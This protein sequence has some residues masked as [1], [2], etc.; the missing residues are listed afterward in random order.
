MLELPDSKAIS[1]WKHFNTLHLPNGDTLRSLRLVVIQE[2]VRSTRRF[3]ACSDGITFFGEA[4]SYLTIAVEAR[5][6]DA[7]Q[8]YVLTRR[9]HNGGFLFENSLDQL[10]L[11]YKVGPYV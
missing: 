10:L 5:V 1:K 9:Y 6:F 4:I 8:S 11:K 2:N 3:E 7:D